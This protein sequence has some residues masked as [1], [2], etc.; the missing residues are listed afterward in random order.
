MSE[1]IDVRC[2]GPGCTA[3]IGCVN[4][5]PWESELSIAQDA[6]WIEDHGRLVCSVPCRDAAR[7]DGEGFELVMH[8]DGRVERLPAAE[9]SRPVAFV[10]VDTHIAIGSVAGHLVNTK[11][12]VVVNSGVLSMQFDPAS[13][14]TFARNL[15]MAADQADALIADA[16]LLSAQEVVSWLTVRGDSPPPVPLIEAIEAAS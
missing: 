2:D 5:E 3:G 15:L 6:G 13:A 10:A 11:P 4:P 16:Y 8:M 7:L 12:R 14:R 9:P 1:H